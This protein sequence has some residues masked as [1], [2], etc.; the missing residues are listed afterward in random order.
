MKDP[1]CYM[2][3]LLQDMTLWKVAKGIWLELCFSITHWL[4][5]YYQMYFLL[6][7]QRSIAL[8]RHF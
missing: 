3:F 1:N 6:E 5:G 4:F 8:Y 2:V 7:A